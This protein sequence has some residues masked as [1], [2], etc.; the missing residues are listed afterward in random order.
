MLFLDDFLEML[1]ELPS[2]LKERCAELRSL[3]E[4]V[5]TGLE[6]NDQAILEY[7]NEAERMSETEK[8][9]RYQQ[10]K[11]EYQRLRTLAE[12]KVAIAERMQELV[13]KYVQHLEKEKTHFKYELEA[14]NP[15]VTENIE[16]RFSTYVQSVIS[17]RKERKRKHN[18]NGQNGSSQLY[19]DM[20]SKPR[21]M[22]SDD[23]L[24]SSAVQSDL[25]LVDDDLFPLSLSSHHN[26]SHAIS[27]R[28]KKDRDDHQ[29]KKRPSISHSL[30]NS[31]SVSSSL[32]GLGGMSPAVSE[33][34][35]SGSVAA[36]DHSP[37][38]SF[39]GASFG[40]ST[41][42]LSFVGAESR[43]GRPRK[44][45][46]RVQEM[47]TEAVQRQRRH[48]SNS[49]QVELDG[50]LEENSDSDDNCRSWCFCGSPSYG[51][52][53]A[54]DNKQCRYQWFHYGCVGVESIPKGKWYCPDC[55]SRLDINTLLSK[56]PEPALY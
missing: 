23:F 50:D 7:F 35:W 4:V 27:N 28:M 30:K 52:M 19:Q 14:D 18:N 24:L 48:H 54:C 9:E 51:Q 16:T 5:Q 34:S 32:T 41:P 36:D 15:G 53:V 49:H 37:N 3:D 33:K 29:P 55:S 2:E 26:N 21:K 39:L 38:S 22:S 12:D 31:A 13:E 44:L 11:T 25:G 10:L 8:Q 6:K 17:M 56:I 40:L 43:H 47:F 45:T 1:D 20:L 42:A 46:S